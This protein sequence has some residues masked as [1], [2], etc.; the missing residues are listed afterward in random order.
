MYAE[1]FVTALNEEYIWNMST[2]CII[3]YTYVLCNYVCMHIYTSDHST[4]N[5]KQH[6]IIQNNDYM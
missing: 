4:V 1:S 2:V 3:M 5:T 6:Y